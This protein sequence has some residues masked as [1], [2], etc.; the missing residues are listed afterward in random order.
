MCVWLLTASVRFHRE[1][2]SVGKAIHVSCVLNKTNHYLLVGRLQASIVYVRETNIF[3]ILFYFVDFQITLKNNTFTIFLSFCRL[4]YRPSYNAIPNDQGAY[5]K[6]NTSCIKHRRP[7]LAMKNTGVAVCH[8]SLSHVTRPP[9]SDNDK[10]HNAY[11][12]S[13]ET[14]FFV[15]KEWEIFKGCRA[16]VVF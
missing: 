12:L 10:K 16:L 13:S 15:K 11:V 9:V 7:A 5:I 1:A 3:I 8:P 14:F 6:A 2:C 4:F